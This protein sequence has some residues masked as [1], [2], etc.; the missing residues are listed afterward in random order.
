MAALLP[1]LDCLFRLLHHLSPPDSC[2]YFLFLLYSFEIWVGDGS[3]FNAQFWTLVSSRPTLARRRRGPFRPSRVLLLPVVSSLLLFLALCSSSSISPPKPFFFPPS[4]GRHCLRDAT[5]LGKG[6]KTRGAVGKWVKA[7]Q[8]KPY[9][10]V[11]KDAYVPNKVGRRSGQKYGFVRFSEKEKGEKVI[12]EMNGKFVDGHKLDVAW[13]RFQK[14]PAQ[15]LSDQKKAAQKKMVW[16]WIPKKNSGTMPNTPEEVLIKLWW[17]VFMKDSQTITI[18]QPLD[19]APSCP[20]YVEKFVSQVPSCGSYMEDGEEIDSTL[21]PFDGPLELEL[22]LHEKSK[23]CKPSNRGKKSGS[24]NI[25]SN[26]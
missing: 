25:K 22:Q 23:G 6:W 14:R 9:Y 21:R 2:Q 7:F 4:G 19:N 5:G 1:A 18:T 10:G 26:H 11:V 12:E 20:I 15:R 17:K 3:S 24:K 8:L 16:K 13:A